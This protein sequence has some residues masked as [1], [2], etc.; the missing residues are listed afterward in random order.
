MHPYVKS[1]DGHFSSQMGHCWMIISHI[2]HFSHLP[3]VE[4]SHMD[5]LSVIWISAT[6]SNCGLWMILSNWDNVSLGFFN[7]CERVLASYWGNSFCNLGQ[8][9]LLI[10]SILVI[11]SLWRWDHWFVWKHILHWQIRRPSGNK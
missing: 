1:P 5:S 8:A 10:F 3:L 9:S 7:N 2:Y 6:H 4:P 11:R